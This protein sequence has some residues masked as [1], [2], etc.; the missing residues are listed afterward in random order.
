MSEPLQNSCRKLLTDGTVQ[1]VIGYVK[2]PVDSDPAIPGFITKPED[3]QRLQWNDLC[4]L[5]LVTYLSRPEIKKLG[6]AAI[7]VK[8]CDL[9]ALAVLLR[10]SQVSRENL[11]I[12]GM[13]CAGQRSSA[14]AAE[15]NDAASGTLATPYKCTVCDAHQ[16]DAKLCDEV[17]GADSVKNEPVEESTRYAR[18]TEFL[19]KTPEERFAFWKRELSRCIRCY[20][21]R[22]VCP[23]CYCNRC[24]ADRNRPQ[25]ISTS[26]TLKGN[27]AWNITRAFHLA[28]RCVGCGQC[29]SACPMGI[30]LQLLNLTMAKAAEDNFGG[31]R[32]GVTELDPVIG[33]Y[34]VE[35][36]EGFI[37]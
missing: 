25:E 11:Y 24:I 3:C 21:C 32:A 20:A 33:T 12:I 29:S 4:D 18:L 14:A 8:G 26:A 36:K 37:G 35:D 23:L 2:S 19:K 13:A 10:E 1:V 30:D 7:V 5:N 15:N 31:Y 27:V 28:G 34:S 9:R 16:P 6:K 17:I 22:Q